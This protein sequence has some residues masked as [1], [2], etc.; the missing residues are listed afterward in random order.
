MRS[1]GRRRWQSPL[2]PHS[3]TCYHSF[4]A[5][6]PEQEFATGVTIVR[7]TLRYL[8]PALVPCLQGHLSLLPCQYWNHIG[9]FL[10]FL[11]PWA[12]KNL[13]AK[14]CLPTTSGHQQ[15][16]LHTFSCSYSLVF[17]RQL[18]LHWD[19]NEDLV[20]VK[21]SERFNAFSI[22]I[23]PHHLCDRWQVA[24]ARASQHWVTQDTTWGHRAVFLPL[25]SCD[26]WWICFT[27]NLFGS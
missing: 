5:I 27:G 12:K 3:Q 10:S 22:S 2:F 14:S 19:C 24:G 26:Y 13:P 9:E 17:T 15:P 23:P 16:F 11:E 8:Q 18:L 4:G 1:E 21:F 25:V 6:F 20:P 7:T